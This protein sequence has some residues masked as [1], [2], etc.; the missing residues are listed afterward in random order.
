MRDSTGEAGIPVRRG[1]EDVNVAYLGPRG[2]F[3]EEALFQLPEF[4]DTQL[5]PLG[6]FREVLECTESGLYTY[7]F[8]PIENSIEGTVLATLD[9]MIFENTLLIQKEVVLNIHQNLLALPIADKSEIRTIISYPHATAQ[10]HSY[11]KKNFPGVE[12]RA[13]DSTARAAQMVREMEDPSVAAIGPSIAAQIYD[14]KILE[15]WIED[16]SNNKTRFVL[17]GQ[18]GIPAA[19]GQDK[20]S[21]VCFQLA[22]QPGSLLHILD[23]FAKRSINLTKLESRPTKVV[24]G[25]YCF[26]I[27]LEGHVSDQEVGEC[28]EE[29]SDSGV[30]VK[31][32]GSYPQ[33]R[34]LNKEEVREASAETLGH[35]GKGWIRELLDPLG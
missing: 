30:T 25:E 34:S 23:H 7:G 13:S 16:F 33:A 8:L 6:S 11:I 2:T 9:P 10:C 4:K 22:D 1:G 12:V 32:L 35:V 26:I 28:L 20:T 21:I 19:T 15:N 14:L 29:I 24:M 18:K 3:T 5:V 31:L 17:F 27:D